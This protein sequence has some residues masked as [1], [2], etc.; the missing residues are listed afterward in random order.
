[1]RHPP[2]PFG[3]PPA[4]IKIGAFGKKGQRCLPRGKI[5]AGRTPCMCV[6]P[7][8]SVS[9]RP[10]RSF[11]PIGE[12]RNVRN[13]LRQNAA[14]LSKTLLALLHGLGCPVLRHAGPDHSRCGRAPV[15]EYR[16]KG[17]FRFLSG[18]ALGVAAAVRPISGETSSQ[19]PPLRPGA[20]FA[21]PGHQ[22]SGRS[23]PPDAAGIRLLSAVLRRQRAGQR[24]QHAE[25]HH[26]L[27]V[28]GLSERLCG[29]D[30]LF[31][32]LLS[33]RNCRFSC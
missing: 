26:V 27:S 21:V 33:R 2:C 29:L 3:Y 12:T 1:M 10:A 14:P 11:L 25:H 16:A 9:I 20:L 8:L 15:P 4:N 30:G 31:H 7:A 6:R 32:P 5:R 19:P 24:Q 13:T 23:A 18:P 22:G 17:L 28:L